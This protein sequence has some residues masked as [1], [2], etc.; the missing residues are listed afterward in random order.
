MVNRGGAEDTK[1]R[2]ANIKAQ[3]LFD[4]FPEILQKGVVQDIKRHTC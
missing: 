2:L 3:T 4:A 1:Q